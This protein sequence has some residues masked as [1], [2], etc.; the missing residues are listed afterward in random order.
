MKPTTI[1]LLQK[2][3][4]EKKRFA[5]ITAYD[6]SFAKLFADEGINMLLVGD[7]LGMTVQGSRLHPA[8]YR[9]RYRP[10]TPRRPPRRAKTACCLPTCRSWPMPPPEQTFANAAIVM[11]AGANM[12]KLEGGAWLADTV[13]ML[14][15]RAVPVCGHLGLT[16]QS[17]NVFGG[18]KSAGSRR[19]GADPV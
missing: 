9:G 6:H 5:T 4:Q 13:R 7:S 19:C 12:V 14:A 3:K 15:E 11:R 2:C 10:I 18:Y 8:G 1:A 16:P 17:V